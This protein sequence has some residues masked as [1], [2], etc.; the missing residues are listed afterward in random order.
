MRIAMF[1]PVW[2]PVP[3]DR[4]G[5][6]EAIVSL[7]TEGLVERGVEVTLFAS[8]DSLTQAKHVFVFDRA[9]SKRIGETFWELNHA[10]A[11]LTRLD[12]YDIVHDHSGLL[13]LTLFGLTST[14]VLHTVHGPL[15]GEAGD[16]YAAACS[17]THD[18]G[19]VSL[20]QAQRRPRPRLPWVANVPNSIDLSRY[21]F[22]REPGDFLL[23]LGR[24]SP[25][26]GAHRAI[27]V[28]RQTG[29][30]L[31]MAAKCREPGE[32]AYF[33]EKIRPHLCQDISYVGEVG[34]EEKSRLLAGAHALLVPIDWEEPFGLVMIEALACGTPVIALRRGSVPEVLDH[35]RTG[36]I[37]DDLADMAAAVDMVRSLDPHELRDEVEKRFTP[38]RMIDGYLAAY[39]RL[40]GPIVDRV[41]ELVESTESAPLAVAAA[42]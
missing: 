31:L 22:R 1:S 34:H 39:S 13:G 41:P 36:F 5:G 27:E 20:T 37:A 9:P 10:L 4:Y 14:P 3:P 38:D 17:V 26:K 8:G 25:E 32:R 28:A 40:L 7:L 16:M 42:G 2:F 15:A 30:P 23:F 24:M 33:D 21:P 11:C 19:L 35:G 12:D 29:R 6:T 18:I